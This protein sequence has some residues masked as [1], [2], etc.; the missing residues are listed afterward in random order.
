LRKLLVLLSTAA[1]VA[2][3]PLVMLPGGKLSGGVK[4]VPADWSFS[5]SIDTVQLETR[6]RDPYSVN[7][8]G[9][10]AGA[11]FYI[12]GSKK[13]RW[14]AHIAEDPNVRLKLGDDVYE[15]RAELT[16]DP[17]DLDAFLAAVKRKYDFEPEP[18]QRAEAVLL[19]L[20]AR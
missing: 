1:V 3:G 7:V 19:K 14:I 2:C 9:T 20:E 15:L 17:A 10:A 4:P 18:D 6:P 11:D 12:G 13:N 16:D 5:D 8:W